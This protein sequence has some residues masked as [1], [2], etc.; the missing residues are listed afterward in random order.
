MK[1][2]A[3]LKISYLA[4]IQ[5]HKGHLIFLSYK[6]FYQRKLQYFLNRSKSYEPR[7]ELL[8]SGEDRR[9]LGSSY[10]LLCQ[11]NIAYS[12]QSLF[13]NGSITPW[14]PCSFQSHSEYVQISDFL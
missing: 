13:L 5:Q 8:A 10:V 11:Q 7:K 14:V 2:S 1:F 9:R 4:T 12:V 3:G 6:N